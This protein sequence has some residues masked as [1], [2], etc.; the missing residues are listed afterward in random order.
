MT[1]Q[2]EAYLEQTLD[3]LIAAINALAKEWKRYNDE[4]ARK[5]AEDDEE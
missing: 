3:K 4:A 1:D 2:A 5:K